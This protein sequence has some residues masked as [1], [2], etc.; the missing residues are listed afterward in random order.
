MRRAM[1]LADDLYRIDGITGANVYLV[2]AED[3]LTLVDAGMPGNAETILA[4][5]RAI[6]LEPS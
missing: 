3:G 1:R 5:I 4:A 6:G 2:V